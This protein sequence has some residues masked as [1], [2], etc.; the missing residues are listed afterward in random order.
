MALELAPLL[1]DATQRTV[2]TLGVREA[3]EF[4]GALMRKVRGIY[5]QREM[6]FFVDAVEH[7][8]S[9]NPDGAIELL[10]HIDH[11]ETAETLLP[12]IASGFAENFEL[13]RAARNPSLSLRS[14]S[15]A[16]KFRENEISL[17]SL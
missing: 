10:E 2:S 9:A 3:W 8:A 16:G 11:A 14:N 1:R 15:N 5:P 7:H 6:S 12:A 13:T 17:P 4:I